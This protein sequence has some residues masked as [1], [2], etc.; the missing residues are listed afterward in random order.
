MRAS[1]LTLLCVVGIFIGCTRPPDYP[2]EP[3]IEF[4]QF[5]KSTLN[6]GFSNNDT[7]FMTIS[8][9]DGDGD[10]GS[11]STLNF[12]IIATRDG[13]APPAYIIPSI[14]EQGTG[15]GIS[16]EIT[17]RLFTT[18]C[19]PPVVSDAC[20]DE[21]PTAIDTVVYEIYIED[22]SGKRSNTILTDPLFIRCN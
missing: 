1:I 21:D 18:C 15:N 14:P 7:T 9:T 4:K 22:R 17:V 11:D 6:Q 5:S 20:E 2:D 3:V 8:F 19:I 12:H 16:G 13:F 10:I